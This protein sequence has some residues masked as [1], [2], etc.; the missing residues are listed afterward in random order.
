MHF[1]L[2]CSSS[3]PCELLALLVDVFGCGALL[4]SRGPCLAIRTLQMPLM[5]LLRVLFLFREL[6][7]LLYVTSLQIPRPSGLRPLG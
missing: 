2:V 7:A 3:F 6:L 4:R 5:R 1:A